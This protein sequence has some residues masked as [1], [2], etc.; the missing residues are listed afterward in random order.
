MGCVGV[1]IFTQD[2]YVLRATVAPSVQVLENAETVINIAKFSAFLILSSHS[3][4]LAVR[5]SGFHSTIMVSGFLAVVALW[6]SPIKADAASV[7]FLKCA[8]LLAI[9]SRL[10]GPAIEKAL[11]YISAAVR[12]AEISV[13]ANSLF[14]RKP[15]R[16][17]LASIHESQST[18]SAVASVLDHSSLSYVTRVSHSLFFEATFLDSHSISFNTGMYQD[19]IAEACTLPTCLGYLIIAMPHR[20]TSDG[21]IIAT[22]G[23]K[24]HSFCAKNTATLAEI[25][26]LSTQTYFLHSNILAVIQEVKLLSDRTLQTEPALSNT[27]SLAPANETLSSRRRQ[28]KCVAFCKP[29]LKP[30]PAADPSA[31]YDMNFSFRPV[32]SFEEHA[33]ARPLGGKG[34]SA[35]EEA[36]LRALTSS[37][38]STKGSSML[39]EVRSEA[40]HPRTVDRVAPS[41]PSRTRVRKAREIGRRAFEDSLMKGIAPPV[42]YTLRS[43]RLLV[44]PLKISP[45]PDYDAGAANFKLSFVGVFYQPESSSPNASRHRGRSSEHACLLETLSPTI[46]QGLLALLHSKGIPPRLF[47]RIAT[48][49][50]SV[51]ANVLGKLA[52]FTMSPF[53]KFISATHAGLARTHDNSSTRSLGALH[54]LA[55]ARRSEFQRSTSRLHPARGEAVPSTP[56]HQSDSLP[57]KPRTLLLPCTSSLLTSSPSQNKDSS[58][59]SD[60]PPPE[61]NTPT[62]SEADVVPEEFLRLN[63]KD[64]HYIVLDSSFDDTK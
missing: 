18:Y 13:T 42:V 50:D 63:P 45:L 16:S 11:P 30:K 7:V 31:V 53:S 54:P 48:S 15:S 14:Q 46:R 47:A 21:D 27:S 58:V 60:N 3:R 4:A 19:I 25:V 33:A 22:Y 29:C 56:L 6:D 39:D 61:K 5:I 62:A 26:R 43:L 55:K 1:I 23:N 10:S 52:R 8:L 34:A 51:A 59:G 40:A 64:P 24:L 28:R 17:D 38:K 41:L 2:G 12:Q 35:E 57:L 20:S 44:Q 36:G 37:Q 32:G 49:F 9:V